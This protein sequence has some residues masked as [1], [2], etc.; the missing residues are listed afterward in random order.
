[1][2]RAL[3]TAITKRS[4]SH[5]HI[6]N[7]RPFQQTRTKMDFGGQTGGG[8][9]C[10]NCKCYLTSCSRSFKLPATVTVPFRPWVNGGRRLVGRRRTE[11]PFPLFSPGISR[12]FRGCTSRRQRGC[13]APCLRKLRDTVLASLPL[14]FCVS[15]IPALQHTTFLPSVGLETVVLSCDKAFS[16]A[17]QPGLSFWLALSSLI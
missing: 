10:F 1:M 8:R 15:D 3:L 7:I 16:P 5:F 11:R 14:D 17:H 2:H 9:A 13:R 6:Q 12:R 4:S